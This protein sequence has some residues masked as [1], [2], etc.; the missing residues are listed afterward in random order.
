[1]RLIGRHFATTQAIAVE[2]SS[3]RIR[4]VD[5]I[6]AASLPADAPW[7]APGLVDLQVHGYDRR[8]FSTPTLSE[9]D[10]SRVSLLMDRFGLTQ[11]C[12]TIA[13]DHHGPLCRALKTI[14]RACETDRRVSRRVAGIHLKGPYLSAEDG[15]RGFVRRD[16]IRPPDF[17]E[18]QRLQEAAGGRI[19]LLTLAPEY[20]QAPAF[21]ARAAAAGVVVAI[22]HTAADGNSIKA[23]VDAGAK[24]ST[25]LGNGTHVRLR[26]HP[27]YIWDQLAEDRLLASFI[28][29]GQHLPASVVKAFVRAKSPARCILVS[30]L[31]GVAGTPPGTYR[32]THMGDVEVW[33]DGRIVIAGKHGPLAGASLPLGA[34]VS[35][36]MRWAGVSL[37]QAIKM[38]SIRP[39]ELI[40]G[41][42]V[43]LTPGQTADLVQFDL[44]DPGS[45]QSGDSLTVRA[46]IKAGEAVFGSPFKRDR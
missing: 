46:T 23:A 8:E 29:D 6:P 44:P 32:G 38:A 16:V 9:E 5:P 41:D 10:V 18:F 24:L 21:I 25:H 27:N 4:S 43:S 14:G 15:P 36:V 31:A 39:A 11:Y 35:N 42:I 34:G 17:D 30:D 19:R 2:I 45:P 22:G 13:A 40:G 33:R 37:D 26:R 20:E 28:V 3:S 12:P 1:M 7:I